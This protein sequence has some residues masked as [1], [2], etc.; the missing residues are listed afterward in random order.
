M[1]AQE[2]GAAIV[3]VAAMAI[4]GIVIWC[5]PAAADQKPILR[6]MTPIGVLDGKRFEGRLIA[7]GDETGPVDDFV[8]ARGKFH[9]EACQEWG[10][11]PGP[12]W[13]RIKAGRVQFLAEL[14]S[15]DNGVMT[16][17]GTVDGTHLKA[18]VDWVKSRWYWT[19]EKTFSFT[20]TS[21][22]N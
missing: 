18:R 16:Y 10:F 7:R 3:R 17:R 12:Y 22:Q 15:E 11:S 19:M 20:G 2:T 6:G 9:S 13:V 21:A 8:F 5:F 4:L 1:M 14:D